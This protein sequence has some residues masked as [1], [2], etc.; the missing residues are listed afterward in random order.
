MK[1]L[2]YL[3]LDAPVQLLLDYLVPV[4]YPILPK[5]L[6]ELNERKKALRLRTRKLAPVRL[7]IN[8]NTERGIQILKQGSN[9]EEIAE[10]GIKDLILK[11]P[12]FRIM[13]FEAN[14][15]V[16]DGIVLPAD[17]EK[18]L[19]SQEFDLLMVCVA[20]V[21]IIEVKSWSNINPDGSH[22]SPDGKLLKPA[23]LQS[24]GK[25]K[26]LRDILG[27]ET[28]VY[29]LVYLP[30]LAPHDAPAALHPSYVCDVSQ[31]ILAIR[32]KMR[33]LKNAQ[34][35]DV[36]GVYQRI[37]RHLD[38][39][40]EAKLRHMIW[41]ADNH[42]SEDTV[43]LKRLYEETRKLE[44]DAIGNPSWWAGNWRLVRHTLASMTLWAGAA[45]L[46]LT[47]DIPKPSIADGDSGKAK[48]EKQ[49]SQKAK[50]ESAKKKA[51]K[52]TRKNVNKEVSG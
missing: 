42:P 8:Q 25:I 28:P 15:N 27:D 49:A 23:H 46:V 6:V 5:G 20:G 13:L 22:F 10:C 32:D 18:G 44:D 51:P 52:D 45:F 1:L 31:L 9:A 3:F 12:D 21:F 4:L 36:G 24:T 37:K 43:E 17:K 35:I 34:I 33:H 38:N 39:G 41:L 26:R 11:A 29:G 14:G 7:R 16:W 19:P 2:Y 47:W 30:R 40:G 48:V 50:T